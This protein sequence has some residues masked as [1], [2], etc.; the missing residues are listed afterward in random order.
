MDF[1]RLSKTIS[2]ILRHNPWV[3]ELELDEEGWV[4]VSMLL[5]ALHRDSRRWRSVTP[6]DLEQLIAQSDKQRFEIRDGSIRAL[7]GHSIATKLKKERGT[8]PDILYHGT[9]DRA[10]E[11]IMADGLRPMSRQYVHLSVDTEMAQEV[12]KRKGGQLLILQVDA[13]R[14]AQDGIVFYVGNDR[15]WLVDF[16]PSLYLS[17]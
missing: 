3:F 14:A 5:E 7:Y 12:G 6:A 13:A 17:Y 11:A 9:S 16:V 4:T 8:P 10:L 1:V 2:F 15:V